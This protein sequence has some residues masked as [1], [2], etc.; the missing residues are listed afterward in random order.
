MIFSKFAWKDNSILELSNATRA[1]I[2][3]RKIRLNLLTG[4]PE[5]YPFEKF[6]DTLEGIQLQDNF[7]SPTIYHFH[8]EFGLLMAGLGHTITDE[9]PLVVEI[10][11]AK[12]SL[13]KKPSTKLSQIPLKALERPTWSEY[14]GAFEYIQEELL[15]GNSYQLNLTY[16]YDFETDDVI[17][18]RDICNFFFSKKKLAPYA[19]ATFLG[20]EMYLSN[21]PE[22][23]FDYSNGKIRTMP[24]KGTKERGKDWKVAWQAILNDQKEIGEL[25]MITDL[26]RNDLN[27]LDRPVAKVIKE[28]APLLVPGLVHQYSQIEVQIQN[29]ISLLKVM[30]SLFPGGSIVGAPKKKTMEILQR[31]E[32][33]NR[34][35][36]CGSTLLCMG[37]R[38]VANINIRTASLSIQDRLWRYGAGGGVTLLSKPSAEFQE[39][40]SKVSSFLSFLNAPG[41]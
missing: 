17:D 10:E 16:P 24:I 28:R 11:Y 33:F 9:M 13:K 15:K 26:L 18:P 30:N 8:Y 12:K 1:Y 19:H 36:Y 3:Y 25:N 21:S 22:C 34:G 2:Y 23:L 29:K 32:R 35:I 31:V 6:L 7:K 14:K 5:T 4:F 27:R 38:K 37:E 20:D 39:M 41:Y 40:E